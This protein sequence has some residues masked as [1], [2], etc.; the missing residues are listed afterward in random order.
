MSNRSWF[1]A[2]EGQQKGPF[3]EGQLRDLITRGAVRAD[4]LVWTEGMAGWQKAGDIP[5]L[6][7]GGS[8]PPVI[9]QSDGLPASAGGYAGGPLSI[10][11]DLWP[12][13]GRCLLF[14]I[15]LMLVI[16]APWTA[17]SFY[18]WMASRIH[19]PGRPNFAFTGEVGDIW[20]VFVAMGLLSY[21]GLSDSYIV[22]LVAIPVQAFLSWM[23]IR[24]IA[25]NLASN[26][27]RLPIAFDGSALGYIG[28]FVLLYISF[29][30]IIGWA[31]V[32][33]AWMRWNFRN[34]VGTQRE[35]I[36][37]ASGLDV[38]WRTIAFSFGCLLIIPIPWLLRWYISWYVS[39]IALVNRTA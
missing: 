6:V 35:V 21:A 11:V 20:Y 30:T 39:Q 14:V 25:G 12:L 17:T 33:T 29:I 1:Y 3:P 37:N 13:L 28:W 32:T 9:S 2:S 23:S 26:G 7:P 5:G 27:Q 15:G 10:D 4:T 24:W 22:Q 8:R 34:I 36:F 18:R 16:P 31:W 19:V 38:L